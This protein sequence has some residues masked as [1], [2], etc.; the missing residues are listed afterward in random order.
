MAASNVGG[1]TID[2][3]GGLGIQLPKNIANGTKNITLRRERN[4]I[5]KTCL[6]IDVH[7]P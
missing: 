3:W 1:S 6:I 4:I 7:A 2:Y 5:G